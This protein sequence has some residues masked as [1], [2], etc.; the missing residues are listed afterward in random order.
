[1]DLPCSNVYDGLG[2]VEEWSS[3][4]DGWITLIF[5]HVDEQQISGDVVV[6]DLDKDV[7]GYPFHKAKGLVR[8]LQLRVGGDHRH[9]T[10][11]K[12][13]RYIGHNVDADPMSQTVLQK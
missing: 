5:T 7:F 3:Q 11:Q 9:S 12:F 1:M 4:D 8:Q 10:I 2:G 6:V 13:I